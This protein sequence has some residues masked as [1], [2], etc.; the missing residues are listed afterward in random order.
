MRYVR[1]TARSFV[2]DRIYEPGDEGLVDDNVVG[3][4]VVDVAT[5]EA[6]H[7]LVA[8]HEHEPAFLDHTSDAPHPSG[9]GMIQS[10]SVEVTPT[11]RPEVGGEVEKDG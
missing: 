5:G 9:V 2:A 1:F 11:Q 10:S 3:A 7:H 4:H 6:T 8:G